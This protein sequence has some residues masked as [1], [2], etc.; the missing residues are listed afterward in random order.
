MSAAPDGPGPDL[1]EAA[2][3]DLRAG[4]LLRQELPT[5]EWPDWADLPPPIRRRLRSFI[6]SVETIRRRGR[7]SPAAGREG[8]RM[9][10]R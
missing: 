2:Y 7:E 1:A 5:W 4:V 8:R 3:R 10:E 6:G 9:V